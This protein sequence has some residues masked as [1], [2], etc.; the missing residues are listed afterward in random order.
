MATRRQEALQ[1]FPV[2]VGREHDRRHADVRL[3]DPLDVTLY[4]QT[5]LEEQPKLHVD[6]L[7]AEA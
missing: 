3:A 1:I 2:Q 6:Q 7:G 5:G 4:E